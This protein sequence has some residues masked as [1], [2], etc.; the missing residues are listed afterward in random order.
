MYIFNRILIC[1]NDL[2]FDIMK[3]YVMNEREII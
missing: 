3:I 1:L 2:N